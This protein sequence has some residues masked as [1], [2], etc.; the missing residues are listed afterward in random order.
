MRYYCV[1][2]LC[3][4]IE[5]FFG[6][7]KNRHLTLCTAHKSKGLEWDRVFILN[8]ECFM[9][10]WVKQDWAIQQ[11]KNIVYVAITRA[12]KDLV[13]IKEKCWK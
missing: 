10:K 1:D 13:Y 4:F 3:S 8:S 12:K 6:V 2:T 5:N 7:E 11:E 9:P